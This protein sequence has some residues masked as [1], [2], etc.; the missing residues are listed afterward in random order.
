M[1]AIAPHW[2][3]QKDSW[4]EAACLLERLAFPSGWLC[5]FAESLEGE[6]AR[7]LPVIQL[8]A[9]SVATVLKIVRVA[10]INAD[11][12]LP[13]YFV[14]TP[15]LL[16]SVTGMPAAISLLLP[17]ITA[18]SSQPGAS[19]TTLFSATRAVDSAMCL[20]LHRH[21]ELCPLMVLGSCHV[22]MII[23]RAVV[24]LLCYSGPS[25]TRRDAHWSVRRLSHYAACLSTHIA[26]RAGCNSGFVPGSLQLRDLLARPL[27][28]LLHSPLLD[29]LVALQHVMVGTLARLQQSWESDEDTSDICRMHQTTASMCPDAMDSQVAMQVGHTYYSRANCTSN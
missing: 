4:G 24:E 16:Q 19:S 10:G 6:D 8:L 25:T 15:A 14:S 5:R 29:T 27:L 22:E 13:C 18:A 23:N 7:S 28:Q 26:F 21:P 12:Q 11:S 9:S 2:Q 3:A 1:R 17:R 20:S